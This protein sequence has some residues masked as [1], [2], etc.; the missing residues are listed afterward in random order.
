[1]FQF[2]VLFIVGLGHVFI[3]RHEFLI[4]YTV[5]I[6]DQEPYLYHLSYYTIFIL[7]TTFYHMVSSKVLTETP[8]S[9]FAMFCRLLLLSIRTRH[10]NG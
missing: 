7:K 3:F 8:F 1:M 10:K 6:N 5:I 4:K 9:I 2:L